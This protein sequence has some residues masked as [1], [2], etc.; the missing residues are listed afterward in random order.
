MPRT[1]VGAK[2]ASWGV[3]LALIA[4]PMVSLHARAE[5]T[6]QKHADITI[7]TDRDFDAAHGVRG[8]AGTDASP[9][10][11]SGW[12]VKN[13]TIRDTA[14]HVEIRDNV[15]TGRL[16]LNFIGAGA[17]VHH[18][19]V[20]DLR[21]NENVK[22][23]GEPTS[24][25]IAENVF[26]NVGQLRHW[27]GYF[28]RNIVGG[29]PDGTGKATAVRA[30][31]F[32]GFNGA[33]FV[34]NLVYGYVDVRLH[35]HHHSSAWGAATHDHRTMAAG[36]HA[37]HQAMMVDHS[38]RWH[39]LFVAGNKIYS[40][41]Q[42]ALRY[43]DEN[44]NAND[45]TNASETDPALRLPHVH[46]TAVHLTGNELH[47]AGVYVD[48]FNADSRLHKATARGIAEVRDNTIY[49]QDPSN[50]VSVSIDTNDGLRD[51]RDG[52]VVQQA[53]DVS[54]LIQ[55]N[56]VI[57]PVPDTLNATLQPLDASAGINLKTIDIAD[58]KIVNNEVSYRT[59][60]VMARD[61][62]AKVSWSVT[63]LKTTG[64]TQDVSYDRSVANPPG[65]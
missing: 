35:G 44:H 55:G 51:R 5:T 30:V 50:S 40:T 60:G 64:V 52:I 7:S 23:K 61:M 56:K 16:T 6:V 43:F 10:V 27:D 3:I 11:I 15:V 53:K 58:I 38:S 65:R 39:E 13:L 1:R 47:G 22:R 33:R 14:S 59:Y 41:G 48:I 19:R 25:T 54:V 20:G 4:L 8:G 37:G 34:D 46:H 57:A 42:W 21:V 24:G 9:F 63:G 62:T 32:D 29:A 17:H 26:G 2:S 31:N 45:T 28:E 49:L 12:S 18:N 36:E